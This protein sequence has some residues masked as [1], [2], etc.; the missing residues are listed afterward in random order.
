MPVPKKRKTGYGLT[1]PHLCPNQLCHRK[2]T[3]KQGMTN[4]FQ[5]YSQCSEIAGSG[6]EN[7]QPATATTLADPCVDT[8]SDD[9]ADAPFDFEAEYPENAVDA[10]A[11][12]A[13]P[14]Q[15]A[16]A[17]Q[18]IFGN[19]HVVVRQAGVTSTVAEYVE[20]SLLKITDDANIPHYLYKDILEWAAGAKARGY[21]FRPSRTSRPAQI[22]SFEKR[23][24]LQSCRPQQATIV[25]PEDNLRIE[26][27][28]FDFVQQL[29]SLLTDKSLTGDLT[30][31]DV[32]QDNP[33]G[34]YVSPTGRLGP[35]NSGSWYHNA[36][37]SLCEPNSND[38]LC[39]IIYGCDETIVGSSQ[40]RAS[41]TPLLFTLSIF[42][43][44]LR[45]KRTS[46]RPLG[47]VYD[48]AQH[49]KGM[50]SSG[51]HV[52]RILLPEEKSSRYHRMLAKILASHIA[53]QKANGIQ[54]VTVELGS[55]RAENRNIKTPVGIILGDMQGGDKHCGS[56]IG[57]SKDLARLCRQCNVSGNESGD[58]LV[59]CRK[60]S[61]VKIRQYV[62]D[63]EVDI[64][65]S[66]SQNNVYTAWFDCDFGGCALGV[67]S[68]AMPVEALHAVEGGLMKYVAKILYEVDLKASMC[69]QL[70]ILV[71]GLCQLDR[72]HYM[73]S[74]GNKA[75]PRL[76]FKDG[77]TSL[78]NLPSAHVVGV[79]LTIVVISLTDAGKALFE[80]AFS[81]T[82]QERHVG[83][84]RL[85]DMRY[86]FSMLLSYWSWLKQ[87]Y[88]WK[89][90]DRPAQKKA[91]WAIRKMLEE[92]MKL[93]PRAE[94]NGWFTAKI[95]EQ[96][97][98]AS[99]IARN[100]SPRNTYSGPLEHTHLNVKEDARRTQMNRSVLD[101]QLGNRSAE[102]HIIKYAY[103]RICVAHECYHDPTNIEPSQLRG[104]R[105]YVAFTR[106]PGRT[107]N[108]AFCWKY[109]T[110]SPPP[111][112]AFNV[113][114]DTVR[115]R[116]AE[117]PDPALVVTCAI[118]TEYARQ[119]VI[120]RAHPHYRSK[121]PWHD[122][123]MIR[124]EKSDL[125][126][127]RN[128]T[129]QEASHTDAVFHGDTPEI[130]SEHHYAPGKILAF[131]DTG[132]NQI[133]AVVLCCAFRHIRSGVFSTY[134]KVEYVDAQRTRPCIMLIDVNAIVRHCL[135]VP[136]NKEE[137]GYHEIWERERWATEFV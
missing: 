117:S 98:V 23:F 84:K 89:C 66:I 6:F 49:G 79:L 85:N 53:V 11:G 95:H 130:A 75:M 1:A 111:M 51:R 120:F 80:K 36:W 123:V 129:Y 103:D 104:S 30:Q 19:A 22:A 59:K 12:P 4:H 81:P 43:E 107:I 56:K 25:F 40:G 74:G 65:K 61:M 133:S 96:M 24:S 99:D 87:E 14:D 37:D 60:M 16:L 78:A 5:H 82:Q 112:R 91:E 106:S 128:K 27:T 72:Q 88:F 55:W 100:G 93:W 125:D 108:T 3:S 68:A 62:L 77:V 109:G 137:H 15:A 42:N 116:F 41:V 64:L 9:D 2:F 114:R 90:G 76:L 13:L 52:P 32:P 135:M 46:W 31:L 83:V 122:W 118:H 71:G 92:L 18:G 124:Y 20:L 26:I 47:Y 131:V 21:D 50:A 63:G 8:D 102:S 101:A 17:A 33:F 45:N 67:F 126:K 97:H 28:Y 113:I 58:P 54:N 136:E 57:Y 34:K 127:A 10:A 39:P 86:V 119:G 69:G 35:F 38:W 94:G 105:G 110:G 48:L 73:S 115:H 121:H 29:H 44:H 132:A 134:W 70:D 7:S